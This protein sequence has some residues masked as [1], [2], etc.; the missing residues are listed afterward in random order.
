MDQLLRA[1]SRARAAEL[2][3][4]HA[5]RPRQ[6]QGAATPDEVQLLARLRV[7]ATQVARRRAEGRALRLGAQLLVLRVALLGRL[8]RVSGVHVVLG[9]RADL[10]CGGPVDQ[11]GDERL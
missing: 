6:R 10:S 9:L 7:V 2:P 5:V 8:R 3:A 4:L 11:P 1:L